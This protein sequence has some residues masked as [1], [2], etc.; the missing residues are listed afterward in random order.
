MKRSGRIAASI[1]GGLVCS[2][3]CLVVPAVFLPLLFPLSLKDS[4]AKGEVAVPMVMGAIF[5]L[6]AFGGF[7]L[8]WKLVGRY[9]PEPEHT[10]NLRL[11]SHDR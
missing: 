8:C 10:V 9:S 5:L 1:L 6:S 4:V 3:V 7:V 11:D 2:K